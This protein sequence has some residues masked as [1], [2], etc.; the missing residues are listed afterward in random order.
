L[1]TEAISQTVDAEGP[2]EISST[3]TEANAAQVLLEAADRADLLVVGS[4]GHGG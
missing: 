2:V 4:R 3:V 1:L